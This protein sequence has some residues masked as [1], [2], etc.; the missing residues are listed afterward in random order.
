[1][2]S[3]HSHIH[4][5]LNEAASLVSGISG[6]PAWQLRTKQLGLPVIAWILLATLFL[7][8]AVPMAVKFKRDRRLRGVFI[9]MEDLRPVGAAAPSTRPIPASAPVDGPKITLRVRFSRN[10]DQSVDV[11]VDVPDKAT[12]GDLK[13]ILV[14]QFLPEDPEDTC[15]WVGMRTR[16]TPAFRDKVMLKLLKG[17]LGGFD[18]GPEPYNDAPLSELEIKD[19]VE[20]IMLAQG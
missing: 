16:H 6:I 15:V 18:F 3:L 2:A 9:R 5:A 17:S 7:A 19:K 14:R 11:D 12:L 8:V 1:M 20:L 10:E 4:D 13:K